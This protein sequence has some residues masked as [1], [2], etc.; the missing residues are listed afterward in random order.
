[1]AAQAYLRGHWAP[2]MAARTCRVMFCTLTSTGTLAGSPFQETFKKHV[3]KNQDQP[4]G[5]IVEREGTI[6]WSNVMQTERYEKNHKIDS[7]ALETEKETEKETAK[8]E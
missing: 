4:Q 2:E 3:R 7:P 8:E 5:E 1:M 6:H